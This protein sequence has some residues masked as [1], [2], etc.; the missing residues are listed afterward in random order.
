MG[1][2]LLGVV[3]VMLTSL[4]QPCLHNSK[5]M[6]SSSQEDLMFFIIELLGL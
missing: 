1:R 5:G 6:A 2:V 3:L 4:H